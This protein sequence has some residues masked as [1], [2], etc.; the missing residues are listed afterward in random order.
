[1]GNGVE[2]FAKIFFVSAGTLLG[3][4]LFSGFIGLLSVGSLFT[5]GAV[6]ATAVGLGSLFKLR[7]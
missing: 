5:F 3:V 6:G 4:V 2:S 1:M 7:R